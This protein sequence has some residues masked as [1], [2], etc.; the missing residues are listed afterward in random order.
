METS[1]IF[2]CTRGSW[3]SRVK[4]PFRHLLSDTALGI[5]GRVYLKS[6]DPSEKP[7]L[8]FK[9]SEGP[10]NYDAGILVVGIKAA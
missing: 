2:S 9:Y 1:Q 7:A 8:D 6:N 4:T 5:K 3:T 10:N